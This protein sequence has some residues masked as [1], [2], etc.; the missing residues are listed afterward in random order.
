M[1]WTRSSRPRSELRE[2]DY[3]DSFNVGT[4]RQTTIGEL[5]E[6]AREL[7][8]IAEPADFTMPPRRWDIGDWYANS[9]RA[10]KVLGW[11]ARTP[12]RD[13]LERMTVDWYRGLAAGALS[14]LDQGGRARRRVQ[15]QRDRRLLSRRPAIPVMYE[16]FTATFTKLGIDYEIIFVNDASPDNGEDVI[17]EITNATAASSVSPT[18][19]T[20]A[21]RRP[22]AAAWSSPP[23]TRSCCSTATSRTR[24]S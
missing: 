6:V 1:S 5:A 21:R 16:R 2:D 18:R 17:R 7:F 20:S 3:G 22:S 12:L 10:Q 19:A 4:G 13:G 24:P 23:R 8:G 11:E 9:A 14:E 15:H